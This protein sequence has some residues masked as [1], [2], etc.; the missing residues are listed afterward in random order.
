MKIEYRSQ[1]IRT[2]K[3]DDAPGYNAEVQDDHFHPWED[4][5]APAG[6]TEKEAVQH[7]KEYIDAGLEAT[8]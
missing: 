1:T 5:M 4:T 6:L 2:V 3:Y 7:A 8:D